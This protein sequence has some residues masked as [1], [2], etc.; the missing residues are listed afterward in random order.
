VPG[1]GLAGKMG[2]KGMGGED[3][4]RR[5]NAMFRGASGRGG[6]SG[7]GPGMTMPNGPGGPPRGLGNL[8]RA[9]TGGAPGS[10]PG[11]SGGFGG[12]DEDEE[13]LNLLEV[14]IYGVASLYEKFPTKPPTPEGA[15]AEGTP[16]GSTPT[17]PA[18]PGQVSAPSK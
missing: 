8:M 12:D 13:N 3:D 16:P 2:G 14:A 6:F 4:G 5:N 17:A 7:V 18:L 1:A 15:T 10:F 9:M 11:R